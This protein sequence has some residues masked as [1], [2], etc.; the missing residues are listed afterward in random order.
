MRIQ[1]PILRDLK[2]VYS[3]A[4]SAAFFFDL[5]AE[6]LRLDLERLFDLDLERLLGLLDFLERLFEDLREADL[7]LDRDLLF[8]EAFGVLLLRLAERF[9]LLRRLALL[10]R[11]GAFGVR[12]LLAELLRDAERDA[13]LERLFDDLGVLLRLLV[14]R[15]FLAPFLFSALRFLEARL[16]LLGDLAL[17][18]GRRR[19][20]TDLLLERLGV[21]LRRFGVLDLFFCFFFE[22]DLP[23][24][25][26]VRA[27]FF[28]IPS[29]LLRF[30]SMVALYVFRASTWA[31]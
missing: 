10:E 8:F 1:G 22:G 17:R 2:S 30:S 26:G 11:L 13:D 6:L 9:E 29:S 7:D 19:R 16:G 28:L 20:E 18:P 24:L 3:V 27:R 21:L 15:D 4:V 25:E 14:A 5:R 12:A 31:W 23:P